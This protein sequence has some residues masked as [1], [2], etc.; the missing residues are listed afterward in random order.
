MILEKYFPNK[1]MMLA[2]NFISTASKP[3][4]IQDKPAFEAGKISFAQRQSGLHE[5]PMMPMPNFISAASKPLEIQ[6]FVPVHG[7]LTR[8]SCVFGDF[9]GNTSYEEIYENISKNLANPGVEQ[10]VLDVDSPGGEVAGLF[11]LCDF[12][13]QAKRE[14]PIIALA[15]DDCLSAAYAIAASCSKVLVSKTSAVG[16]IG[17][18]ATHLDISEADKKDGLKYTT[19]FKGARK[20]DLNPHEPLGNEALAALDRECER[21]YEMFVELVA[22]GRNISAATAKATE[23]GI[24]Y[25]ANSVRAGLAD[26]ITTFFEKEKIMEVEEEIAGNPGASTVLA[27]SSAVESAALEDGQNHY[28]SEISEI[29]KLCK[30]A[31]MPE[32]LTDFVE[33]GVSVEEARDALMKALAS[34]TEDL[35]SAVLPRQMA[36]ESPVVTAAKAR[37]ATS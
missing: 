36:A 15:N 16:S 5:K 18:I 23:A 25:G 28:R 3:L 9:F 4:E 7:V 26:D 17:V 29:A 20:N 37:V 13:R 8:R 32:K 2:S 14:K 12:I 1:P 21:L 30:L 6:G 34:K 24:F 27:E 33:A 31:K 35:T 11:D 19:I 10:I 22:G